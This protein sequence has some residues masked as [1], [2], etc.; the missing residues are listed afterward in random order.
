M[1]K[2]ITAPLLSAL[3]FPGV[4]HLNVQQ[5]YRALA[6]ILSSVGALYFVMQTVMLV[7]RRLVDQFM[8]GEIALDVT[9]MRELM[10]RVATPAEIE[11]GEMAVM[12]LVVIWLIALIDAFYLG[13]KYD[14]ALAV[15]EDNTAV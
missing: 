10:Y 13:R 1:A 14:R 15:A 8:S 3:V 11:Q 5:P 7:A 12:A 9:N 4:G 2:A 6:F